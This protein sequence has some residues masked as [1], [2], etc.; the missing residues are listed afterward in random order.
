M[1][2]LTVDHGEKTSVQFLKS[3]NQLAD[4]PVKHAWQEVLCLNVL[5]EEEWGLL[6]DRMADMLVLRCSSPAYPPA[7]TLRGR[8]SHHRAQI[9]PQINTAREEWNK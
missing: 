4:T 7:W 1:W 6:D 5:T 9:A 8:Q 2:L 3:L